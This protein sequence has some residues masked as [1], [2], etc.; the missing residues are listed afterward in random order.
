M[1]FLY[2]NVLYFN[3]IFVLDHQCPFKGNTVCRS[4]YTRCN[5]WPRQTLHQNVEASIWIYF[6]T[7]SL[8][9]S[10]A[11]FFGMLPQFYYLPMLVLFSSFQSLRFVT[12]NIF[13][14][15]IWPTLLQNTQEV[16]FVELV[17]CM[18]VPIILYNLQLM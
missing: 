10:Y 8:K 1:Y 17:L 12:D 18:I 7:L 11:T 16:T 13:K 9:C 6:V 14:Y 15:K 2:F 4:P 5:N 3:V